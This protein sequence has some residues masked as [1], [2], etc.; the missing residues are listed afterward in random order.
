MLSPAD[1]NDLWQTFADHWISEAHDLT[2]WPGGTFESIA[3]YVDL[4][5]LVVCLLWCLYGFASLIR[6]LRGSQVP[7]TTLSFSVLIPFYAEPAGALRTALS[8]AAVTPPVS[9]I[10]LVD[11]GSP[12]G[13]GAD[14]IDPAALPPRTRI[15][16]L[17]TN[18]GKAAA[19]N[20]ALAEAT[21]DILVCLDADTVVH[22]TDWL[23]MLAKFQQRNVGAVTGKIW[24]S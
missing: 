15:V 12:P 20:A 1:L 18:G 4:F 3:E 8:V 14:A 24:P 5:P 11:D 16:R 19:L 6:T 23:P 17:H 21:A 7:E 9:E 13:A 2:E 10:I 22:S